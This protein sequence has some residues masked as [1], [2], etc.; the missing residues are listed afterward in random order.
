MERIK[1]YDRFIKTLLKEIPKLIETID[2]GPVENKTGIRDL[3]TEVDRGIEKFL[4]EKILEKFPDHQILG[5]ETYDPEKTYDL[6]NLWVID[7]IDGTT[8]FVKQRNDFCTLIAYFEDGQPI[9][10]Y[11]YEVDK[12]D[13]YWAMAGDRVYL[14]DQPLEKPKDLAL[15]QSIISTDIRRMNGNRPELFQGLLM[16]SFGMRSVG[17]SGLDGSRVIAGRFGGYLNYRGGPWDFA[18]FFLMADLLDLVFVNLKGEKLDLSDYS[19]YII[20]NK[21]VYDDFKKI[22]D[23]L[24]L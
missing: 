16:E 1:E 10:S 2:M 6:K 13:L 21:K 20:A 11:I 7:P 22:S 8:N 23:Q 24:G 17:T 9:L 19:D 5:E 15:S 4:T 18:P 12:D 14:N 3:V